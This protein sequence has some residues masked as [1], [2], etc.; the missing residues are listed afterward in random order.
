MFTN[1]H[2]LLI[3]YQKHQPP[4]GHCRPLRD[5]ASLPPSLHPLVL[6]ANARGHSPPGNPL[7]TL[8]WVPWVRVED[9]HSP[10]CSPWQIPQC[11]PQPC[12]T[13]SAQA[14]LPSLTPLPGESADPP[15]R[16]SFPPSCGP[17]PH[18]SLFSILHISPWYLDT[19]STPD[20]HSPTWQGLRS[21][22]YKAVHT[23]TL[24]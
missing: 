13:P 10:P 19:C 23:H 14:W 15:G 20:P 11:H 21:T 24:F 4:W 12:S 1:P 9:L 18:P 16:C 17:S 7:A 5:P 8:P 22:P 3:P 2:L 6:A